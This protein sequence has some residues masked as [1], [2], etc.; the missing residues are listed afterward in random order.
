MQID[1]EKNNHGEWMPEHESVT[2]GIRKLLQLRMSFVPYLYS[3]FNEYHTTGKP[4]IRA[5]VLD[6]PH[7][8][9]VRQIDDE[10]MFGDSVLV[11]PMFAGDTN[12]SVYLPAG[13]W[14]DFW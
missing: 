13:D 7:D 12:R 11:A 5:L 9:N 8:K 6:W 4:P 14:Y 1:K 10:F 3:A 2:A